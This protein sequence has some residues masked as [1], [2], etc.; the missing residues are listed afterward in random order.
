VYTAVTAV[1]R[2]QAFESCGLVAPLLNRRVT[3]SRRAE[4]LTARSQAG[5]ATHGDDQSRSN[6]RRNPHID[7]H[8]RQELS[9]SSS[10]LRHGASTGEPCC[11]CNSDN[12][13]LA[14]SFPVQ[15]LVFST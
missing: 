4:S 12:A 1:I 14:P 5:L 15:T 11:C 3:T 2:G 8:A 10:R 13:P 7:R 9:I 6:V